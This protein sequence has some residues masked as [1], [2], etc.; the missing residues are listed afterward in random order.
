MQGLQTATWHYSRSLGS[1][2]QY[3]S[4]VSLKDVGEQPVTWMQWHYGQLNRCPD[5]F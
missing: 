4:W 3:G 1:P 2:P 5:F